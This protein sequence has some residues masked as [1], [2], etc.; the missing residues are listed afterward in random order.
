MSAKRKDSGDDGT[1]RIMNTE[2]AAKYL[3]VSVSWLNQARATRNGPPFHR[4]GTGRRAVVR[5]LRE[6]LDDFL[7]GSRI[8]GDDAA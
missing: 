2:Q 6:E 3:G 1:P 7:R 5:Y 4:Y 8:G